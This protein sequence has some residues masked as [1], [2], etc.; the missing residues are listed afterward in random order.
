MLPKKIFYYL[1]LFLFTVIFTGIFL[2][3]NYYSANSFVSSFNY[4]L[5]INEMIFKFN[6]KFFEYIYYNFPKIYMYSSLFVIL[7]P[8]FCVKNLFK[9]HHSLLDCLLIFILIFFIF[10]GL[11]FPF[12]LFDYPDILNTLEYYFI[13]LCFFSLIITIFLSFRISESLMFYLKKLF[14]FLYN[15]IRL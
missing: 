1:F 3:V 11:I 14:I 15:K 5:L 2:F 9:K 7:I 4:W 13:F 10:I 12:D 8:I 6:L